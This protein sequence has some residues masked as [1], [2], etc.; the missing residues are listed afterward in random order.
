[1]RFILMMNAATKDWSFFKWTAEEREAHM[2]YYRRMNDE[3]REAGEF[4]TVEGLAQPTTA[5]IVQVGK[6]NE[7]VVTDGPF[8][9]SKEFLAGF[10]IID[11]EDAKRAYAIAARAS[12]APGAKGEPCRTP[13]EVREVMSH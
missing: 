4:V 8:P 11:V 2:A 1:M 13:I 5:R 6:N 7:P 12:A 10:W 3:L 9:E